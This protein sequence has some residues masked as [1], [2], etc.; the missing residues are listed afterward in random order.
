M[1]LE[2]YILYTKPSTLVIKPANVKMMVPAMSEFF[3]KD[4][5]S[6]FVLYKKIFQFGHKYDNFI[7]KGGSAMFL[8]S[9]I[10]TLVIDQWSKW[11][12]RKNYDVEEPERYIAGGRLFIDHTHNKGL[13]LSKLKDKPKL[14]KWLNVMAM[15]L[16]SFLMIPIF[17]NRKLSPLHELALGSLIGGGIGNLI[18]R[19]KDGYVTDFIGFTRMKKVI[20]NFADFFIFIGAGL[21]LIL[22]LISGIKK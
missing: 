12:I 16:V 19:L 3:L 5:T 15:V 21:L 6:P 13:M 11:V 17:K 14:V 2:I 7:Y 9:S 1:R 18:D 4:I 20:Y 8:V 10:V 22:E